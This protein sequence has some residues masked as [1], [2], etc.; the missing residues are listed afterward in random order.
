MKKMKIIATRIPNPLDEK[1]ARLFEEEFG[2]GETGIVLFP[3]ASIEFN[4][5]SEAY[6]LAKKYNIGIIGTVINNNTQTSIILSKDDLKFGPINYRGEFIPPISNS[7]PLENL[8]SNGAL[9]DFYFNDKLLNFRAGNREFKSILRICS[10]IGL[11]YVGNNIANL[12]LIPS[13]LEHPTNWF[14]KTISR[15]IRNLTNDAKIVYSP[16]TTQKNN[17]NKQMGIYD[18]HLN[19]VGKIKGDYAVLDI[20]D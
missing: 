2:K 12:M 11:P 1:A 9:A 15:F 6:T 3:E 16:L 5:T 20:K 14:D 18:I 13:A 17:V 4:K 19:Q 7:A 10:D 8:L